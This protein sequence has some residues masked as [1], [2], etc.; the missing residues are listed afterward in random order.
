MAMRAKA[1]LHVFGDSLDSVV[2][3]EVLGRG[4]K[5]LV[6]IV[7]HLQ[8]MGRNMDFILQSQAILG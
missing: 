4:G 6:I 8:V 2:Y 7:H 5:D 1:D 3:V